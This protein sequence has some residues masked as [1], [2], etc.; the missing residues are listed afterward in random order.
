[1]NLDQSKKPS[2]KKIQS[3]LSTI[4][5]SVYWVILLIITIFIQHRFFIYSGIYS[6]FG[7]RMG[8]EGDGYYNLSIFLQNIYNL[9]TFNFYSF[10]GD[11]Q[12][13]WGNIIGIT[14]HN[15]ASTH[16]FAPV[17]LITKN[18]IFAYNF[19]YF[20][21]I[22][23]LQIGMYFLTLR[24]TNNK[25]ISFFS[26]LFIPLS[27]AVKT[28]YTGHIHASYY[29]FLPFLTLIIDTLFSSQ[30]NKFSKPYL[31]FLYLSFA[32]TFYW[33]IF[34]DWHSFVF[35]SV[36][37]FFFTLFKAKLVITNFSF[38]KWRLITVSLI[39]CAILGT[40]IPF[41]LKTIDASKTMNAVRTAQDV[42]ST[43]GNYNDF[44]GLQYS[45]IPIVDLSTPLAPHSELIQSNTKKLQSSVF[46]SAYFPDAITIGVFWILLL[47]SLPWTYL[48][49]IKKGSYY[50]REYV[51]LLI[52]MFS[53]IVSIGTYLKLSGSST[54]EVKLPFYYIREFIYP[55]QA[56][57]AVWR[58]TILNYCIAL[59][60]CS[61]VIAKL[62]N[63]INFSTVSTFARKLSIVYGTVILLLTMSIVNQTWRGDAYQAIEYDK[64]LA[65]TLT[66]LSD[67]NSRQ[68]TTYVLRTPLPWNYF[69]ADYYHYQFSNYNYLTNK[70]TINWI[71]GGI[72]G[73]YPAEYVFIESLNQDGQNLDLLID[74]LA[75]KKVDLI[76]QELDN[77]VIADPS[78]QTT[79][80]QYYET[81]NKELSRYYELITSDSKRNFWKRKQEMNQEKTIDSLTYSI[82]TSTT[83]PVSGVID[84]A[85][86]IE[87]LTDKI[88]P[89]PVQVEP[90][91]F[92]ISLNQNGKT[93][94]TK[95][96]KIGLPAFLPHH[97]GL[98]HF[99]SISIKNAKEG[100]ASLSV[101]LQDKLIAEKSI[102]LISHNDYSSLIK[103]HEQNPIQ[104]DE[105][106]PPQAY[107]I[108]YPIRFYL[109]PV[110]LKIKPIAGVIT[111][112]TVSNM[113]KKQYN[114]RSSLIYFDDIQE[115]NNYKVDPQTNP[116]KQIDCKLP[117]TLFPKDTV[118]IWCTQ[119]TNVYEPNK[120]YY[121]I[122]KLY[123]L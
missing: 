96:T 3:L 83:H 57:R 37:F 74:I 41:V 76:I 105:S 85:I 82:Q 101:T 44:F 52:F 48:M 49:I 116:D 36:W 31:I 26:A 9:S 99:Q 34:A 51:F 29:W 42:S 89:N 28:F 84:F 60:L 111:N 20:G 121:T 78:I 93:I 6:N 123:L 80:Q 15:W 97:Q 90:S 43:N 103:K 115:N 12:T 120:D 81:S 77:P 69:R 92:V 117:F 4:P 65:N 95:E 79:H 100:E 47:I 67:N 46:S 70:R 27:P 68:L 35:S 71:G 10:Q 55:F 63:S 62:W 108:N 17:L 19:V 122:P 53:V 7:S 33:M 32:Y 21:N 50:Q 16:I 98:T 106:S 109:I 1:M 104:F 64:G 114:L 66:T 2:I 25:Y 87:N 39:G 13:W 54:S 110:P 107:H 73:T 119:L 113:R 102:N 23:L 72:A 40:S 22:F 94:S 5:A 59:L 38:F 56:I 91:K 24:Y 86:N 8:S 58:I 11:H 61:I 30:K 14:G 75:S 18:P 118:T 88:W 45:L 112:S